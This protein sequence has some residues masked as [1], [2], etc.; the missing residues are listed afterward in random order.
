[1][2]DKPKNGP[3]FDESGEFMPPLDFS[4]IVFPIYTQALIK[5]GLL[6]DPRTNQL[7]TNLEYAKRL[8]D[9]L[10]LLR[11]RTKGNLEAEEENF[12]EA[13]LSQLKLNYLKKIDAIKL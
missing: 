1:M 7:E 6:E 11:D 10:D 9:I 4:S 12:L 8:I 2:N 3:E 5:L 13:I